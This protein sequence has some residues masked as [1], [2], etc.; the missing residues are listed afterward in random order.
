MGG[1]RR[2]GGVEERMGQTTEGERTVGGGRG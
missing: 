1:K 2:D